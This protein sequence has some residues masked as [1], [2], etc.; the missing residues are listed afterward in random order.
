MQILGISAFYHDSA[1]CLVRDGRIVA[2]VEEERLTRQKHDN[3]FPAHAIRS[4]LEGGKTSGAELDAVVF[5][6]KPLTKLERIFQTA[7]RF[8]ERSE[9][10]LTAQ[11]QHYMRTSLQ[12]PALVADVC[13]YRKDIL[14]CEHHLSHAAAAYFCSPFDEAAILTVDGVGEWA[15]TS[16]FHGKGRAITPLR[17]IHYPH[18]LG[19]LYAALTAFL[20]FEVNEGEYKVMGLA[21]YGQPKYLDQLR[22][23]IA[24]YDD[25]SFALDLSYFSFTHSQTEMYSAKLI[26]LLGP[27]RQP[28]SP[29]QEHY[30]N[31]ASSLQK[32]IE[33]AILN[34]ARAAQRLTGAKHLCLSGGVAHNI[35]ANARIRDSKIFESM[36]IH[37]A[38]GDSGSAIGAALYGFYQLSNAER[39]IDPAAPYMGPDFGDAAIEAVLQRRGLSYEKLGREELLTQTAEL[40]ADNFVIGWCQGQMEFGPRALGNR[41]ILANPCHPD[42]K[43]ILNARVKHREDFRP[44]APAVLAECAD[45][46]FAAAAASPAM[47]YAFK[48][49]PDKQG[50]IPAVT[51]VDGT[52]RPQ[53]VRREDN[54]LFYD[55][56]K[57]FAALS[58]VPVMINTSFNI[59]GEPIVCT[60]D[61]AINCFLGTDIDFLAVGSYLVRK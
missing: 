53:T 14:Y 15:T 36:Y 52:A 6:E 60:P 28:G 33:E 56:I 19:L 27:A 29:M 34:L 47:L 35:V 10:F 21:S 39:V 38:S 22:R 3:G 4:V 42:M 45:D 31:I 43:N 32:L 51:H 5:Y 13:G 37:F 1:A 48:V 49:R 57:S 16:L 46:Y 23:L 59:R 41:S 50:V 30:K 40:I 55:L 17:A 8:S 20:G 58:G 12:L 11:L 24:L 7:R 61:D 2:A 54:P 9:E 26:E 18:S 44:F 25:G